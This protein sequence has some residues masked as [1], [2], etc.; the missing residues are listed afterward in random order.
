[1]KNYLNLDGLTHFLSKLLDKFNT[2]LGGK[3]DKVDGMGLSTNDF[4]TD[5]KEKLATIEEGATRVLVDSELSSDSSNPVENK[6]VNEAIS[7]L[8]TTFQDVAE[9]IH[10]KVDK[11][12]GMGLSTNDFTNEEKEK[13]AGIA[14]GAEVNV[15]SDWNVTDDSADDYIKNKP[16]IA[17]DDD[18]IAM[19]QE[20]DAFPVVM[21][22]DGSIMTDEDGSILLI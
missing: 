9:A 20:I 21:D 22:E 11:V 3:V 12:E 6:V 4:T 2:M 18:I 13:L 19:M 14:E 5:E 10:D 1:M 17:T 8:N 7:G 16:E 15:Q